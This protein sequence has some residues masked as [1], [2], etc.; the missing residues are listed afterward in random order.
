M[1]VWVSPLTSISQKAVKSNRDDC[2]R[3]ARRAA[4]L[5]IDLGRRM[6]GKWESAPPALLENVRDFE[7]W[8]LILCLASICHVLNV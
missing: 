4:R 3:L 2:F 5:L 6:E 1:V 7:R 8:E